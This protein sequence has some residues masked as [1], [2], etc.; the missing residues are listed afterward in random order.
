M[1]CASCGSA[2]P[3]GAAFCGN[4][5]ARVD[6]GVLRVTL[7]EPSAPSSTVATAPNAAA[8]PPPPRMSA[9]SG[10]APPGMPAPPSLPATTGGTSSK[11]LVGAVI[12]AVGAGIVIIGAL[13]SWVGSAAF[14]DLNSFRVSYG[15]LFDFES[16][17]NTHAGVGILLVVL[18][19]AGL[20]TSFIPRVGL[21]RNLCGAVVFLVV[22]LYLVQTARL[23]DDMSTFSSPDL[24]DFLGPG[25]YVTGVGALMMAAAPPRW[26]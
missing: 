17:S 8:P 20:A 16:G 25:V 7:D 11:N 6:N 1:N 9:V 24:A 2:L 13:L 14:V 19:V 3:D 18:A 26:R 5:G 15:Y 10:Y 22:V 21:V 4:C 12:G 23:V